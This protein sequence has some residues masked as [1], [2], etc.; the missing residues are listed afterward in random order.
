MKNILFVC[1][2]NRLRSPTAEQIFADHPA[3]EVSSAGTNHDAENPLTGELVAWAD[4][5]F[6]MERAHRNKLQRHFRS[7]LNG[8]RVVVLDIP[9]DYAFMDPQLIALL[10]ARM[11]R[12]LPPATAAIAM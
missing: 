12:H 9:D 1:S 4:L 5:I 11:A 7:A 10:R 8:K 2:Q 3:I 6:V